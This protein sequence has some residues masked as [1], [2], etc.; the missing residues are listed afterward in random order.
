MSCVEASVGRLKPSPSMTNCRANNTGSGS[1]SEE[2]LSAL[3]YSLLNV[4]LC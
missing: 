4:P 3:K 2:C 1:G